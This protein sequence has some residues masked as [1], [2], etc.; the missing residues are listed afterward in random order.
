MPCPDVECTNVPRETYK[1]SKIDQIQNMNENESLDLIAIVREIGDLKELTS[2]KGFT[3][4]PF[5]RGHF[6]N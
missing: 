2:K 3:F 4:F 6:T 1:C 5:F